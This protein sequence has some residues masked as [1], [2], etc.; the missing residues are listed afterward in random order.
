MNSNSFLILLLFLS[1]LGMESCTQKFTKKN[2]SVSKLNLD[3]EQA[4][5]VTIS[6]SSDG[7]LKAKLRGKKFVHEMEGTQPYIELKDGLHMTFYNP[8]NIV[9]SNITCRRGRY[10]EKSNNVLL[11]DS[12]LIINEKKEELRTEELIWNEVSQKFFT[13]KKV[14]IKTPTQIIYGEGMEANKEFSHYKI[15][16]CSGI[17]AV[18]KNAIP[19]P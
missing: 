1:F 6:Y 18:K 2:E 13:E 10:F 5:S 12:V 19:T 4:D 8:G 17:L 14:T 3:S 9:A 16:K 11:R 7:F 15:L